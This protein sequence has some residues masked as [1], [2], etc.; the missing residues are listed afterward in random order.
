VIAGIADP[1]IDEVKERGAR[2]SDLPLSGSVPFLNLG[3]PP[4]CLP[5]R[6]LAGRECG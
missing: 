3:S 4:Y 6:A 2:A 5:A 1:V